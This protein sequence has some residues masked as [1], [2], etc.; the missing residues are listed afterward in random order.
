ME[1]DTVR[2]LSYICPTCRQSVI[3][4]RDLFSLAAAPTHIS[5]P[6]GWSQLGVE[7]LPSRVELSVPCQFC[8]REHRVSCSSTAFV[9]EKAIAFSCTASGL[10]CCYVGDEGP[11]FAATARLEKAVEQLDEQGEEKGTYLNDT[12]MYEVLS[13]L[14]DIAQRGGISCACGSENWAF[15]VNYSSVDLI[16]GECKAQARIPAAT[17]DDIDDVCC[18]H[19]ILIRGKQA[20]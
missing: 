12:V 1:K 20:P 17:A 8:N 16:C 13:E 15:Q 7:F 2:F 4:Q 6:C 11:V 18:K 10:D 19:S 3:V 14:R 9:R 5:C